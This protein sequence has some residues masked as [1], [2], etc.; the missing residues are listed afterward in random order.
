MTEVV[1]V[2]VC[3]ISIAFMICAWLF[4]MSEQIGS[5]RTRILIMEE[6]LTQLHIRLNY[7]KEEIKKIKG[8]FIWNDESEDE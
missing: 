6:E 3:I 4:P 5:L 1:L 8:Q 2:I 7:Q